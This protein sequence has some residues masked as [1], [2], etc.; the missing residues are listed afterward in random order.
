MGGVK[1]YQGI[2]KLTS[3]ERF[4]TY[5]DRYS[6]NSTGDTLTELDLSGMKSLTYVKV[7]YGWD[8]SNGI[9]YDVGAKKINVSGCTSLQEL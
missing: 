2:K 5:Y 7:N 3:L 8:T 4:E 1:S 6:Y 9:R